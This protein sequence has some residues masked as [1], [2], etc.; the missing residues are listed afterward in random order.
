MRD[1]DS[2]KDKIDIEKVNFS[3]KPS[4]VTSPFNGKLYGCIYITG[5][6]IKTPI[7]FKLLLNEIKFEVFFVILML[8]N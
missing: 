2:T 7:K 8:N 3:G 5:F 1:D 6:E 4:G